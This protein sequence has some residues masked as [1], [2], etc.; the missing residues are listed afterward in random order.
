MEDINELYDMYA[1]DIYKFIMSIALNHEL[2][3][4]IMQ[5][6]FLSAIKSIHTFK[7]H[8]SV[9]TWLFGIA[10]N[11][12]Y[13]YLRKNPKNLKL[14]DINESHYIQENKETY[15]SIMEKIQELKEPQKQIVI[16]R[17]IIGMSFKEIGEVVGKSENYC[18]VNFFREKQKI[19]E[20]IKDE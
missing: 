12:Y 7:G 1:K 17:I 13:T 8:S 15:M 3:E 9:K 20:E 4:D 11:E 10:K 18:R 16:L 2:A 14:E 5:S 19:W 6:T